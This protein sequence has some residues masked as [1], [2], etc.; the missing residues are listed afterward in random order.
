[1]SIKSKGVVVESLFHWADTA[2]KESECLSSESLSLGKPV[3]CDEYT[4][5]PYN[6]CVPNFFYCRGNFVIN[7]HKEN[8]YRN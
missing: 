2:E 7:T 3:L 1:M 8:V 4:V 5:K 6:C